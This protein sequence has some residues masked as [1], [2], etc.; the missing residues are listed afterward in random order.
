[1]L[2]KDGS[3]TLTKKLN[4]TDIA[5]IV[6]KMKYKKYL[7]DAKEGRNKERRE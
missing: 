6:G 2:F 3:A 1:M 7:I 4:T 5:N